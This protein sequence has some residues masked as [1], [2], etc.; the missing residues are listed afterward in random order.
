[1]KDSL[2]KA[3]CDNLI[4]REVPAGLSVGTSFRQSNGDSVGFYI[5][6]DPGDPSLARI[7]DDGLTVST[8]EMSG[9]DLSNG[10]RAEAFSALLR[11]SRV[12]HATQENL[13]HTDFMAVERL[14]MAALEFVAFLIRVQEF[15]LL[16]RENVEDTF[17]D[18]VIRAVR[19]HFSGRASVY[20]D[21]ETEESDPTTRAD[22]VVAP[23]DV[24]PLALFIGTSEPKA[25]EATLLYS[26]IKAK[27]A[28]PAKVMLILKT[29]KPKL[30]RE[31]TLTRAQNRFTVTVF[32]G[33]RED[34]LARMDHELWGYQES[35]H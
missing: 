29:A 19:E 10:P 8:L 6:F 20:V 35:V 16:T 14:P 9:I 13:L 18:D 32:P 30:I 31:N 15:V 17:K 7:E 26:D 11:Q 33:Q 34:V 5:V 2:C 21:D 4:V 23:P 24:A 22:V 27:L 25:L 12:R 3:F 28:R 1:M